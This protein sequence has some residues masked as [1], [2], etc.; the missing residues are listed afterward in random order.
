MQARKPPQQRHAIGLALAQSSVLA[1]LPKQERERPEATFGFV[2]FFYN[3]P[4]TIHAN[5]FKS[6]ISNISA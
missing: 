3:G 1:G 6:L 5:S 2:R 4:G